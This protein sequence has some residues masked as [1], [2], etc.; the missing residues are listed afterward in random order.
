MITSII[1]QAKGFILDP[2]EAFR[3][4]KDDEPGRVFSCFAVLLL[5]NA[6]L[7]SLIAAL[8][9]KLVPI[10]AGVPW[11]Q[12]LPV[13][14]FFALFIGGFILTLIF[15]VW[16][17]LWVYIFGGRMGI[18][19]TLKVVM[20]GSTPRLLFGWI[21]FV[22]FLFL[23]WTLALGILGISELQE[24]DTLKAI[25]VVALAVMIP[26]ILLIILAVYLFTM[27]HTTRTIPVSP[28]NML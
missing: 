23:L 11:A 6:V 14:I 2:V 12:D 10:F 4:S 18:M 22:G 15:G 20:Y 7:A 13:A 17:H 8:K 5:F 28:S 1:D 19:Q 21:P 16:L 27:F 3:R 25:L 9:I 26:I 24:M